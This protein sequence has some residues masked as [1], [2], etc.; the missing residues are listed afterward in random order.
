MM[1]NPFLL[2]S[3]LVSLVFAQD[4][5]WKSAE[6]DNASIID[7][8]INSSSP[9]NAHKLIIN[10]SG[11]YISNVIGPNIGWVQPGLFHVFIAQNSV[12]AN[13]FL[14]SSKESA[15]REFPV[16]MIQ[17]VHSTTTSYL[18]K[19]T[20]QE[21][22]AQG[23]HLTV[24]QAME[25]HTP[26]TTIG[27]GWTLAWQKYRD[28][29]VKDGEYDLNSTASGL[30]RLHFDIIQKSSDATGKKEQTIGFRTYIDGNLSYARSH[31][32]G[33]NYALGIEY[34]DSQPPVFPLLGP[35]VPIIGLGFFI[36]FL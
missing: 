12:D 31:G 25:E 9:E 6:F 19:D 28:W 34:L 35:I 16:H 23:V 14:L 4:G 8:R 24:S 32:W 7:Y 15:P 10:I 13:I 20:L 11:S 36:G 21:S 17:Y 29:S 27:L 18:I 2:I 26:N 5:I 1:K 3:L 33:M 22:F 30:T